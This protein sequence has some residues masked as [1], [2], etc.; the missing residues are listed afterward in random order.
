MDQLSPRNSESN[1]RRFKTCFVASEIIYPELVNKGRTVEE[2][3]IDL[4]VNDDDP[5]LFV[6]YRVEELA[7]KRIFEFV[8]VHL[9]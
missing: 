4:F 1:L 7:P 8:N 9:N 6:K 3:T 5:D 2:I